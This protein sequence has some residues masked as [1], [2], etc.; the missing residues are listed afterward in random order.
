MLRG[1]TENIEHDRCN[2][3]FPVSIGGFQHQCVRRQGHDMVHTIA[4]NG[5]EEDR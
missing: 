5:K 4:W 2:F 3:H 1:M